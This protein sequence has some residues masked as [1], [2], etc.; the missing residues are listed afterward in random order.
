MPSLR[1]VLEPK[2]S[3]FC[4]HNNF[5][6]GFVSDSD[7]VAIS[8]IHFGSPDSSGATD[9]CRPEMRDPGESVASADLDD[10]VRARATH[11]C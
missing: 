7:R 9:F 6:G 8:S 11:A 3:P 5:G 2:N 4:M 10:D 1:E